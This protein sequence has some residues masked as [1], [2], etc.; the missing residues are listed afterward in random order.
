M[1]TKTKEEK[2]EQEIPAVPAANFTLKRHMSHPNGRTS[3]TIEGQKGNLVIFDSLFMDAPPAELVLNVE[4]KPVI[5]KVDKSLEK[6][7][8]A[9]ERARLA[10]EKLKKA[11][12]KLD[13]KKAK[14]ETAQNGETSQSASA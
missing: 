4:V 14:I 1:K 12:E 9:E 7:Q 8:K 11:Q 13:E 3:Y 10:Q 2:Q 5:P 6:A